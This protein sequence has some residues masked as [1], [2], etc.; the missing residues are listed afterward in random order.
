MN[1][2]SGGR[3]IG[4]TKQLLEQAKAVGGTIVCRDPEAMRERAHRCGIT[5]VNIIAYEDIYFAN[6]PV[7]IHDIAK[8]IEDTIP[9]VAGC[10]ITTE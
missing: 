6:K 5:G 3:G 10:T 7:Y 4:K 2:I 8:F 9:N 1:I